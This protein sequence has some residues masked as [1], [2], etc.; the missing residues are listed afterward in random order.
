ML[1]KKMKNRKLLAAAVGLGSSILI[2]TAKEIYDAQH[3]LNHTADKYDAYAT[4]AGGAA[5]TVTISLT[6]VKRVFSRKKTNS[7]NVF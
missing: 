2:G 5:G 4:F 7:Q 6:D 3:P 1:P